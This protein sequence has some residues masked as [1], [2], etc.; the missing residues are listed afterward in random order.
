M[1]VSDRP[2]LHAS[3]LLSAHLA[4]QGLRVR[5]V[6]LA[7]SALQQMYA[8][9]WRIVRATELA[10]FE[11]ERDDLLDELCR[12]AEQLKAAVDECGRLNADLERA[13]AQAT[14]IVPGPRPNALKAALDRA[15]E[16]GL[17]PACGDDR[18]A[19]PS[20]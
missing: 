16:N 15:K 7:E 5:G 18:E 13:R 10:D 1:Q 2:P 4:N 11:Q 6:E 19:W 8:R 14:R 9:G 20:V 12:T 17:H 3:A